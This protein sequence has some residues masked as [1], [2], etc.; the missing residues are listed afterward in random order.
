M[1][2]MDNKTSV[3]T[4][5]AKNNSRKYHSKKNEKLYKEYLE[6]EWQH[7]TTF[8][9]WKEYKNGKKKSKGNMQKPLTAKELKARG[10]NTKSLNQTVR[11]K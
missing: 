7:R 4:S 9:D 6:S 1:G 3:E 5:R 10:Y 11:W 2:G 8:A